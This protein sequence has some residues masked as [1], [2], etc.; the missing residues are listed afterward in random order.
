MIRPE[1]LAEQS[2]SFFDWRF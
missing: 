1:K 2:V